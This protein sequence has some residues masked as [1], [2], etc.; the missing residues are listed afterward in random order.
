M[1]APA[2]VLVPGVDV[3]I[4]GTT[5][6]ASTFD[7]LIEVVVEQSLH[8]PDMA[9]LRFHDVGDQQRPGIA[10]YFSLLDGTT[11]P[12]GGTLEVKLAQ[13]GTPETVFQGE[14][15][16]IELEASEDALPVLTVRGY[17]RSHRLHRNR[18]NR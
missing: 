18:R 5:L 10:A 12:I 11:F 17:A 4:N 2:L 16:A 14:I 15:T 13:D 1:V 9:I 8:L 3:K 6:D 7:R